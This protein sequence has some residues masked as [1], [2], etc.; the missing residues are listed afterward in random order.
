MQTVRQKW[1]QYKTYQRLQRLWEEYL[2]ASNRDEFHAMA[3]QLDEF[4]EA[5]QEA[6]NEQ[7]QAMLSVHVN[8]RLDKIYGDCSEIVVNLL[9]TIERI[10]NHRHKNTILLD[11]AIFYRELINKGLGVSELILQEERYR[12]VVLDTPNLTTRL[13]V[14][15]SKLEHTDT[16]QRALRVLLALGQ[17]DDA[18]LEIGR[19]QGFRKIFRLVSVEDTALTTEIIHTIKRLTETQSEARM[20]L[21]TTEGVEDNRDDNQSSHF[22]SLL[23]GAVGDK[24]TSLVSD[25][26]DIMS[27]ELGRVLNHLGSPANSTRGRV[28]YFHGNPTVTEHK[29]DFLPSATIIEHWLTTLQSGSGNDANGNYAMTTASTMNIIAVESQSL[30]GRWRSLVGL[31]INEPTENAK[32]VRDYLR[33]QG[34]IRSLT[35]ILQR[36]TTLGA[37]SRLELV[38]TLSKLLFDHPA[39]LHRGWESEL[40]SSSSENDDQEEE[41]QDD[42]EDD[43]IQEEDNESKEDIW[44][45]DYFNLL[46]TISLGLNSDLKVADFDAFDL[47]FRIASE[48]KQLTARR[49]AIYCIQEYTRILMQASLPSYN[50]VAGMVL[51]SVGRL[52][53]DQLGRQNGVES[54]FLNIYLQLL[55][56]SY[57]MTDSMLDADESSNATELPEHSMTIDLRHLAAIDPVQ[58]VMAQE[59][60]LSLLQIVGILIEATGRDMELLKVDQGFQILHDAVALSTVICWKAN[61]EEEVEYDADHE[62]LICD[63]AMWLLRECLLCQDAT[64]DV[65][66]KLLKLVLTNLTSSIQL[67]WIIKENDLLWHMMSMISELRQVVNNLAKRHFGELGGIEVLLT[68]LSVSGEETKQLLG[69]TF[70]YEDSWS[71]C[72]QILLEVATVGNVVRDLGQVGFDE[73][74]FSLS[75]AVIPFIA[76]LLAP[77]VLF[78]T[79]L[80]LYDKRNLDSVHHCK[81]E[82]PASQGKPSSHRA[83]PTASRPSS[84]FSDGNRRFKDTGSSFGDHTRGHD[85]ISM[86]SARPR[87]IAGP[88]MDMRT[89]ALLEDIRADS[90]GQIPSPCLS[91]PPE[92]DDAGYTTGDAYIH[93]SRTT[94]TTTTTTTRSHRI[95]SSSLD[96][97]S[98]VDQSI[99]ENDDSLA[100]RLI[101]VVFRDQHAA[102]MAFKLL[103]RVAT[104]GHELQLYYFKLLVQLLHVNPQNQQLICMDQGLEWIIRS[105]IGEILDNTTTLAS[106]S[107]ASLVS[108]IGSHDI[109]PSEAALLLNA[110]YDPLRVVAHH[111]AYSLKHRVD[112]SM[113]SNSYYTSPSTTIIGELQHELLLALLEI[114]TRLDPVYMFSFDGAG[115]HLTFPLDKLPG[116]KTGYTLSCWLRVTAFLGDD[117]GFL[118]YEDAQGCFFELYFRR[119]AQSNRCCLCVRT[120]QH[121][122]PPEDFVFY[123]YDFTNAPGWHHVVLAHSR[124]DMTL[125]IDGQLV[126]TC[127]TFHYPRASSRDRVCTG[128]IGRRGHGSAI[129][130]Y[131]CGQLSGMIFFEGI[132]RES[133][134]RRVF[135]QGPRFTEQ[136]RTLLN[137]DHREALSI[138]PKTCFSDTSTTTTTTTTIAATAITTT[139]SNNSAITTTTSMSNTNAGTTINSTNTSNATVI[140]TA[141]TTANTNTTATNNDHITG[142]H[143]VNP[144]HPAV[145]INSS[146]N[147]TILSGIGTNTIIPLVN[148]NITTTPSTSNTNSSVN[149]AISVL[150]AHGSNYMD[151]ATGFTRSTGCSVHAMRKLGDV[152]QQVGGP[153]V[154][155]PMMETS[156]EYQ[157]IGLNIIVCLLLKSPEN[158]RQFM[159][160]SGFHVVR[161][162]LATSRWPLTMDHFDLLLEI[163]CDGRTEYTHR[164]LVHWEGMDMYTDMLIHAPENVQL[165]AI[166]LLV[167]VLLDL[168]KNLTWWRDGLGLAWLFD[169][170]LLLPATQHQ[171]LFRLL[172][173]MMEDLTATELGIYSILSLMKND[174]TSIISLLASANGLVLLIS[175]LD[176]PSERFRLLV[177]KLLGVLMSY[178]VRQMQTLLGVALNFYRCD[179]PQVNTNNNSNSSASDPSLATTATLGVRKPMLRLS[180]QLTDPLVYPELIRLLLDR[181]M[182]DVKRMLTEDNMTTLWEYPWTEWFAVFL[183]DRGVMEKSN[184]GRIATMIR[185]IAQRMMV[186]DMAR[187]VSVIN[188]LKGAVAENEAFQLQL[189]DDV[190]AYY[191]RRPVLKNLAVLYRH[192]DECQPPNAAIYLRFASC[193]NQIACHT[194]AETRNIMKTIGLFNIRDTLIIN[195]LQA[196]LSTLEQMDISRVAR[197][198]LLMR[199]FHLAEPT[200]RPTIARILLSVFRPSAES[201]RIMAAIIEDPEVIRR[202]FTVSLRGRSDEEFT[203]SSVEDE[204]DYLDDVGSNSNHSYSLNGSVGATLRS[205]TNESHAHECHDADDVIGILVWYFQS[206]PDAILR[207]GKIEQR[208]ET[209][210]APVSMVYR[211]TS[212]SCIGVKSGTRRSQDER[213]AAHGS[214][215]DYHRQRMDSIREAR[216]TRFKAGEESWRLRVHNA[217][218]QSFLM[219]STSH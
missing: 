84:I 111:T 36:C 90:C 92:N 206:D 159:A 64:S 82:R 39:N 1:Q 151:H 101:G 94:I 78:E 89:E 139:T 57:H 93:D 16:K 112:E 60:Y 102:H 165:E 40:A 185:A 11:Q 91:P 143:S 22:G 198:L 35:E 166:H 24:V 117:T 28:D 180:L 37:T 74:P 181:F 163:A 18:K 217:G 154:C 194:A 53:T 218:V 13:L 56:R 184:Y 108:L 7:V 65:A 215:C 176:L 168:R 118:C 129:G 98:Q 30:F 9:Y 51:R 209:L 48:S 135:D 196:D 106:A 205:D 167:D 67:P 50:V 107:L 15:L 120:Q 79:L 124:Q 52:L 25:V 131:F 4:L 173:A 197:L 190:L 71:W 119:L 183:Q 83:T 126:Q 5:F 8:T 47:L 38:E 109:G 147:D 161:H 34:A 6:Y 210:Y 140:N 188:R 96:V 105:M 44:Y 68:I 12:R 164:V 169:F 123:G 211:Q 103:F 138:D 55:R 59:Q 158:R 178:N 114:A 186:F 87:S 100:K 162:L 116:H 73:E 14:L 200:V 133:I 128:V 66:S 144:N 193:L 31:G 75:I 122:M 214:R 160:S 171:F 127:N 104:G 212:S 43:T 99:I 152:I 46:F 10:V 202:F 110:I 69:E 63:M 137:I 27:F 20:R 142:S 23:G 81:I 88:L 155:F 174:N 62:R 132:W 80:P 141:N 216:Q 149:A 21:S 191:E 113:R 204:V 187:R 134:A 58:R 145:H 76:G 219:R 49:H 150:M 95:K 42:D 70:G 86:F 32:A 115:A 213:K 148:S 199:A 182:A 45:Q 125:F 207:R 177:L 54:K 179:Q 153:Q 17:E 157:L 208:I 201:R 195:L 41:E 156:L 77:T 170:L 33:Q 2:L 61:Q 121:P 175:F 97:T 19:Q 85:S 146:N 172:D 26:R 72:C 3:I 189:I 203:R 29:C 130:E 192:L 136:F